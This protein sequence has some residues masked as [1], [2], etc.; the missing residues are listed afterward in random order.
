MELAPITEPALVIQ[1]VCTA[2]GVIPQGNMPA[3]DV[4]TDYLKPKKILLVVDNCEHLIE[5]CAQLCEALLHV[6]A[7]LHIIT[8]SREALGIDGEYAYRVPSL[9][10]PDL[11]G[12]LGAIE[13]SEA[14]NLFMERAI[15]ILPSFELNKS[16]ALSVAQICQRLDGIALA[17]ELAASRRK[18]PK[19]RT[20]RLTAG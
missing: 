7:N 2:L 13:Q 1:T 20:D 5:A 3:L 12:G 9:S 14:V 11:N 16:N 19:R 18:D 10:L 15:A 6:C 17:I 4:L 8:S